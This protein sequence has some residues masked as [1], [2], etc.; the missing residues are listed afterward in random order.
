MAK[1]T[2]TGNVYI[3]M[4]AETKPAAIPMTFSFD[5]SEKCIT[6]NNWTTSQTN[7]AVPQGTVDAPRVVMVEVLEGS[8][9]LATNNTGA[10][11][12]TLSA[13]PTPQAG[14][15]PAMFLFFTFDPAA[16]QLYVTTTAPARARISLFG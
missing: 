16:L 11:A 4:G 15:P 2:F 7:A 12:F 14:D 13:N 6:D 5:Y 10:G 8:L 1:F 9:Q 3:Q